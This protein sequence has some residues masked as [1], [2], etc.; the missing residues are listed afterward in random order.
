[1]LRGPSPQKKN[2]YTPFAVHFIYFF[3]SNSESEYNPGVHLKVNSCTCSDIE[4][5]KKNKYIRN[6]DF[7]FWKMNWLEGIYI[8]MFE[9]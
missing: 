9:K 3:T 6:I 5:N 8:Y 7:S 2:E 1:V 4:A